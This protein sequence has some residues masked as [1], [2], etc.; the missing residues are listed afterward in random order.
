MIFGSLFGPLTPIG[1]MVLLGPLVSSFQPCNQT[2]TQLK[3]YAYVILFV[4]KV[5]C[6]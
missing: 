2:Q 4:M 6:L 1:L 5:M 3:K